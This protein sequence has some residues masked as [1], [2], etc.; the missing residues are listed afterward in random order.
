MLNNFLKILRTLYYLKFSQIIYRLYYTINLRRSV[1]N[2]KK[3]KS[4]NPFFSLENYES[5]NEHN[6]SFL[7]LNQKFVNTI[8]WNFSKHG[9]L[10]TFN[11]NYFD[12]LNQSNIKKDEAISLVYD[13]IEKFTFN[14]IGKHPYTI[15]LRVIN[16]IKFISNHNINDTKIT[17]HLY[18]N[19][20]RLNDKI[21]YHLLG[22]HVLE[23][24]FALWFA[25]HF[26][27]DE[28]IQKKSIN[29]LRKELSRQVLTDGAHF[30]LSPM[31]HCI[32]LGRLLECISLSRSN[33]QG[34]QKNNLD[35]LS[36]KASIMLGW[37]SQIL[38]VDYKTPLVNDSA[39]KIAPSPKALF[40]LAS[41]LNI[42]HRE[43]KLN[44]SG[45]RN[46]KLNKYNLFIDVADVKASYQPGHT[47]A[48][49]FNT[50][51]WHNGK[52]MLVEGGTSTYDNNERRTWE[53]ST[54][55]H[56][57]VTINDKNS[58]EV[59]S[60]FRL[61]RRAKIINL[62]EKDNY[63]KST[64]DGFKYL[65]ALHTRI[66]NWNENQLNILDQ[67]HEKKDLKSIAHFHFHPNCNV[68]IYDK[69]V[70]VDDKCVINFFGN[71]KVVKDIYYYSEEFNFIKKATKIKVQFKGDLKTSFN[72]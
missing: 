15:S 29:L 34:W 66:W 27:E 39:F 47:H 36:S 38:T 63:V 31:Y 45:Y 59:W 3:Q 9:M 62:I 42:K 21:E 1:T 64:H 32:I 37:L 69:S 11:L 26:F 23:N 52:P 55:A 35:F 16:L 20:S 40:D 60:S 24:A 51:L 58:S 46:I 54:E 2:F 33:L 5:F 14:K 13:Y 7:N 25:G 19:V 28:Q 53:R 49:T 67:L 22:N 44:E 30:E 12:Y 10:W 43:S 57:T 65:G 68:N 56:N 4:L 17:N 48:D 41:K 61:G 50:L 18:E 72:F 8:D 70:Y 71:Y 6:F